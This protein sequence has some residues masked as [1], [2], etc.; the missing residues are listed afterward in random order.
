MSSTIRLPIRLLLKFFDETPEYS[1]GHATAIVSVAGEDLGAGLLVDYYRKSGAEAEVLDQLCTQGTQKGK[2]LDRWVR[3]GKNGKSTYFQVEIK[4][5]S[6]HAIGG[7]ILAINASTSEIKG[8]KIESWS[9]EWNGKSF[10]KEAVRKV[11]IPMKPP[12][13]GAKIEPLVCYWM[14]MHPTGKTDALFSVQVPS[15]KFSR[16]W[17][18]SMSAHLRN[19]LESGEKIVK[20]EAPAAKTRLQLLNQMF[21]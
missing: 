17:V 10:K 11:L 7:R 20:I 8:Y 4:N 9:R 14:P 6:A 16:V 18:F 2:R 21:G 5:W 13:V 19:L 3:V 1:R 12:K 15:G